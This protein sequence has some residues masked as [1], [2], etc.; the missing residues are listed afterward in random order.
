MSTIPALA[1]TLEDSHNFD[2]AAYFA[3]ASCFPSPLV[4][5][6][7]ARAAAAAIPAYP[8]RP[9]SA[10]IPANASNPAIAA[11]ALFKNS[12]AIAAGAAVPAFPAKTAT[13][14]VPAVTAVTAVAAVPAKAG[15]DKLVLDLTKYE[16]TETL[17]K[18]TVFVPCNLTL[19]A[20]YNSRSK[21]VGVWVGAGNITRVIADGISI[22]PIA[23]VDTLEKLLYHY[24]MQAGSGATIERVTLGGNSY[25]KIVREIALAPLV[26]EEVN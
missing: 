2:R 12:P 19:E 15:I 18:F 4:A 7:P 16:S 5:A 24:A 21:A 10:A 17:S 6:I 26:P 3:L 14:A 23:G 9:A 20:M 13:L 1:F 11:G 25:F 22:A 8:A